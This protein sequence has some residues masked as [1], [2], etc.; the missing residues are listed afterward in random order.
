MGNNAV[1]GASTVVLEDVPD[2]AVVVGVPARIIKWR[3]ISAMMERLI[4][5]TPIVRLDSI[6]SRIFLKL[7]KNNPGGSVKDRPALFMILDAE[8][9]DSSKWNRGTNERQHGNRHSDDRSKER[10]QVILTMPET[11]SVERR[12]VLKMLGAELVLTPGNWE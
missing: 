1:V 12:K 7:E 6:D 3:R 9:E 8:K 5:S 2:G 4:G 11:M 10:S